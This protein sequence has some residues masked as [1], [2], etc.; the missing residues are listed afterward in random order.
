VL[1]YWPKRCKKK[2]AGEIIENFF[3]FLRRD[4]RKG[5]PFFSLLVFDVM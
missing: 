1:L 5:C 3:W 2:P 4:I